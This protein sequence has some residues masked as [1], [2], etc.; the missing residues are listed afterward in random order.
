MWSPESLID[1][2]SASAPPVAPSFVPSVWKVLSPWKSHR[3]TSLWQDPVWWQWLWGQQLL[4]IVPTPNPRLYPGA[5][6]YWTSRTPSWPRTAS[7]SADSC[8]CRGQWRSRPRV[9]IWRWRG[10]PWRWCHWWDRLTC[11][12]TACGFRAWALAALCVV[13]TWTKSDENGCGRHDGHGLRTAVCC[14]CRRWEIPPLVNCCSRGCDL[15][16]ILEQRENDFYCAQCMQIFPKCLVLATRKNKSHSE[17]TRV[18]T[19]LLIVSDLLC[20]SKCIDS[21][22]KEPQG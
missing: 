16:E 2:Q 4:L 13:A 20:M 8:L 1:N 3:Q 10:T 14:R 22:D 12:R 18:L 9:W 7:S 21:C 15:H 11:P 6:W 5:S 19:G 17:T